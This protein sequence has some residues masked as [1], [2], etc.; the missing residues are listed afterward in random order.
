MQ[1]HTSLLQV[2][3]IP[4][5]DW[6]LTFQAALVIK[7]IQQINSQYKPARVSLKANFG[8]QWWKAC[9]RKKS[10]KKR[11]S[12]SKREDGGLHNY[13][14]HISSSFSR[15][16]FLSSCFGTNR[17]ICQIGRSTQSARWLLKAVYRRWPCLTFDTMDYSVIHQSSHKPLWA[18][19][20]ANQVWEESSGRENEKVFVVING[21][22]VWN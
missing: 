19:A 20:D 10:Y 2:Y 22:K 15:P 3:P 6:W 12:R 1:I 5:R 14:H 7:F 13:F 17:F 11:M 9:R 21:W 18:F 4:C 8:C 16:L